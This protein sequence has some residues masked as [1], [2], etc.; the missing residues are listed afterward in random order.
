VTVSQADRLEA[1]E[2]FTSVVGRKVAGTLMNGLKEIDD[3]IV[4][5]RTELKLLHQSMVV[6]EKTLDGF[7]NW[8]RA[9]FAM[10]FAVNVATFVLL[11]QMR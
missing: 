6:L 3:G 5:I 1:Y 8:N 9:M 4:E 2:A 10:I 7:A 11:Y